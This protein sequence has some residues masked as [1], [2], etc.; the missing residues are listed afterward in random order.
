MWIYYNLFQPVLHL[1]ETEVI[2]GRLHR[3]WDEAKTPYERLLSA[4]G[5]TQQA[6]ERLAMLHARTNPRELRRA[7]HAAIPRLWDLPARPSQTTRVA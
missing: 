1:T 3:H 5:L 7:I 2:D 6:E 4:G